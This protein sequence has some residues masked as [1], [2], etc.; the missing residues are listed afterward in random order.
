MLTIRARCTIDKNLLPTVE[1]PDTRTLV[2]AAAAVSP[3]L[4]SLQAAGFP[5]WW[6]SSSLMGFS[7][8]YVVKI[9]SSRVCT[10]QLLF[11]LCS[12]DVKMLG[13]ETEFFLLKMQLLM[14]SVT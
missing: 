4:L 5:Q 10:L 9:I 3:T 14:I 6:N 8:G 13:A 12:Y 11:Q 1:N 2:I 7:E